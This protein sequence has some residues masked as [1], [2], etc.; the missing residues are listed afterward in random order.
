MILNYIKIAFRSLT[1]N[2]MFSFINIFGLALSMS[3]CMMVILRTK[4]QLSYD[5]FHPYPSR[6]YRVITKV[7]EQKNDP[8]YL[9]STPLPLKNTLEDSSLIDDV[10]KVYTAIHHDASYHDKVIKIS[11]AFTEPSFFHVFGF[12]LLKGNEKT[13]LE[14][15]NSIIITEDAAKRL[16]GSEEALGQ[17]ISLDK[18]GDFSVTGI[19]KQ[20]EQK[21]HLN[22]DVY[23]SSA[24]LPALEKNHLLPEQ[25][26]TWNPFQPLYTYILLK[27]GVSSQRIEQQLKG[28]SNSI[29]KDSKNRSFEFSLQNLSKITPGTEHIYN[30]IGGGEGW[31]K[32]ITETTIALLILLAGCFNYT[33]L[34]VARALT[35]AREV[36]IRKVSG[37]RRYQIFLQ[38]IIESVCISLLSLFFAYILLGFILKYKPFNDGYQFMPDVKLD[39][40]VFFL[41]LLFSILTGMIAGSLPAW[42]LSTFKPVE[43]LKNIRIKKLFGNIT[44]QKSLVVFQFSLSLIILIFLSSFYLQFSHISSLDTGFKTDRIVTISLEGANPELLSN[45]INTISGVKKLTAMSDNFGLGTTGIA[46]VKTDR[47]KQPIQMNFYFGDSSTTSVMG[48][49]LISG[50]NLPQNNSAQEQYVLINETGVKALSLPDNETA[51]GQILNINDTSKVKIVGI[52]KDFYYQGSAN[53]IRPLILRTAAHTANYI[54]VLVNRDDEAIVSQIQKAWKGIFPHKPFTYYWYS[55]QLAARNNQTA[56]YSL[57]GFLAVITIIIG[58]LGLL[59]LVIY[60]VETRR[61]EISIRKV[62]GAEVKQVIMLLSKGYVKLL[63]ISGAIALPLGYLLTSLFLQNFANRI[64]YGLFELVCCFLFLLLIGLTT[65]ISQTWK[66]ALSNPAI[67]LKAE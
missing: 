8:Y 63:V 36:G 40:P 19:L 30:D 56:T 47:D 32:I 6:T 61:K 58:S 27:K 26:S 39:T 64:H 24:S 3:V 21:S 11:G 48:L 1:R 13:A 50:S 20:T 12:K 16:F 34:T 60:T 41:F 65:I 22:F 33:N 37:A 52:I 31:T 51:I 18:L 7:S 38:Y 17:T 54:N 42:I 29:Y 15:P 23:A 53:Y 35:R 46:Q 25:S 67:Y 28:I 4:D 59:G 14:K 55:K 57:L 2:R 62:I 10:V 43:V 45:E 9:A 49:S 66:A 5:R 44:L